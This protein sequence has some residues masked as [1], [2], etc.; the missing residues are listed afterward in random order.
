MVCCLQAEGLVLTLRDLF[1]V[2]FEM[3]KKEIEEAKK[4][5]EE[6]QDNKENEKNEE[7]KDRTA[8][9]VGLLSGRAMV[10][11]FVALKF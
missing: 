3:K 8:S 9:Q 10:L 7:N 2:V 11:L 5:K 6:G 1:Q 4:L